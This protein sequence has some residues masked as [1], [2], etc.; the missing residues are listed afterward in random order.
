MKIQSVKNLRGEIEFRKQLSIQHVTG[1]MLLPD[2]Y[3][4]DQ[5]DEILFERVD[6]TLNDIKKLEQQ[7]ISLSPF[8]ELGAERCQ[9]ALVLTNDFNADGFAVDISYHQLKTAKHFARVFD[10]PKLPLRVCCDINNLPFRNNSFPFA[11]GYQFLH[12]FPSLKPII[13]EIYRI[14]SNGVFFFI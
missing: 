5:H 11:F 9:R 6:T 10:R 3:D 2:Y 12:H 4:K 7:S 14:L 1:E 8:I 13:Q